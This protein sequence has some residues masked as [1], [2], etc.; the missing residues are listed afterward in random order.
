LVIDSFDSFFPQ[1]RSK[2]NIIN[3]WFLELKQLGVTVVV[4]NNSKAK[5]GGDLVDVELILEEV[6][7]GDQFALKVS[8]SKARNLPK[9]QCKSFLVSMGEGGDGLLRMVY[10]EYSQGI[11]ER[12]A[13]LI[14]EGVTQTEV[15]KMLGINQS[16]VSRRVEKARSAGLLEKKGQYLMLTSDGK[17]RIKGKVEDLLP[18]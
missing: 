4:A 7:R 2:S 6:A 11:T 9:D 5:I 1:H 12:V 16:T 15:G 3:N 14:S 17:N 18:D 8:Y 13:Y 10:E